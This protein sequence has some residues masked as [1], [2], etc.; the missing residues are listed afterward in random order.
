MPIIRCLEI[1]GRGIAAKRVFWV[2]TNA[3]ATGF[4]LAMIFTAGNESAG[5][6]LMRAALFAL[7][8][9]V[10][11]SAIDVSPAAAQRS[12][13]GPFSF[14]TPSGYAFCMRSIYGDDDC[15]YANYQQCAR[16]A[17]GIGLSCF[18]NPA[19]AYAPQGAYD[20]P[21]PA[22]RKRKKQRNY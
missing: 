7:L 13:P 16:T 17:S 22:P 9:L 18:A 11:T 15:S 4:V 14:Y 19:L 5:R 21:R 20:E 10:A 1:S 12:N 8:A 2:L 6:P 3:R